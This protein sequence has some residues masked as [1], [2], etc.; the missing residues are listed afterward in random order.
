MIPIMKNNSNESSHYRKIWI[1]FIKTYVTSN[2]K[3]IAMSFVLMIIVAGMTAFSAH[4]IDPIINKVF[5]DKNTSRLWIISS[6]IL[7]TFFIKSIATYFYRLIMSIIEIRI[8][9]KL[10]SDLYKKIVN[11]DIQHFDSLPTGK[12]MSYFIID[13]ELIKNAV[14]SI[15]VNL[16]KEIITI[17][18]L[19]GVMLWKSWQLS[20]FAFIA[21]PIVGYPIYVL[22][23]KLRRI[24]K[25]SRGTHDKLNVHLQD[26]FNGISTIKIYNNEKEEIS[27]TEKILSD[28][29]KLQKRASAYGF[30]SSPLMEFVAGISIASVILYG[31]YNVI[32]GSTTAG[33][34]FSFLTALLMLHKPSKSLSGFGSYIQNAAIS[35]ERIFDTLDI[36][37]TIINKKSIT[38]LDMSSPVIEFKNVS[39]CYNGNECILN[40]IDLKIEKHQK[41]ALVGGSGSGKT[42]IGKLLLRLYDISSGSIEINGHDIRDI[43]ISCLRKNISYVGQ[44]VFMFNDTI[45]SNIIYGSK[46]YSKKD[47]EMAIK[48]SRVDKFTNDMENGLYTKVGQFGNMLSGGQKQRISIARA[49]LKNSPIIIMDEATS[50]LDNI[51]EKEIKDS[52]DELMKNKTSIII[53]HRISTIIDCDVINIL[54][55]GKIVASG[56]HGELIKLNQH[57]KEMCN[58]NVL[59]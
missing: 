6:L 20:L 34:F 23:R 26:S 22:S 2:V 1:R 11:L 25:T 15:V 35:L 31:G 33:E 12:I 8:V 27:R 57:Y 10:S 5:I 13:I 50:A 7:M 53:A 29:A 24:A 4:L 44:D 42:T 28:I 47:L 49:I 59:A 21:V 37:R 40:N 45:L 51:T 30:I 14:N 38:K 58:V 52:I 9:Q 55:M 39:F 54:E 17:I 19:I 48:I 18:A 43:D 32:H 36:K 41:I 3:L 56:T 46:N 16:G